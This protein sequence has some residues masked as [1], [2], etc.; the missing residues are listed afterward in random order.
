[1]K[2]DDQSSEGN[3]DDETDAKQDE[4]VL[5][6]EDPPARSSA[7]P[8]RGKAPVPVRR[9][10][11]PTQVVSYQ[12]PNKRMNNPDVGMVHPE[13]DPDLAKTK[14][15]LSSHID[16]TLRFD[17][18]RSSIEALID[19]AIDSADVDRMRDALSELKRLQAPYL[20]RDGEG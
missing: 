6:T 1:M 11:D 5:V 19:E 2:T 3:I 10:T 13:N 9:K 18:G 7:A 17:I 15:T 12:Y 16:P 4:V 20:A 14:W 8:L